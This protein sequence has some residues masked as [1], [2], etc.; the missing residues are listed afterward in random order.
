ML[1]LDEQIARLADHAEQAAIA[2]EGSAEGR[3]VVV[4]LNHRHQRRRRWVAIAA[5][6]TAAAGVVGLMVVP[7][8]VAPESPAA[9]VPPAASTAAPATNPAATVFPE[10]TAPRPTRFPALPAGDPRDGTVTGGYSGR[11]VGGFDGPVG[12]AVALV[13]RIAGDEIVDGVQIEVL[14]EQRPWITDISDSRGTVTVGGREYD[15]WEERGSPVI[16]WL[17]DRDD[18]RVKISGIDPDAYLTLLGTLPVRDIVV[19]G[20]TVGFNVTPPPGWEVV[21]APTP[22]LPSWIQP[23][24]IVPAPGGGEPFSVDVSLAPDLPGWGSVHRLRRVDVNGV[25]G[26]ITEEAAYIVFWPLGGG[27]W[28]TAVAGTSVDDALELARSVEFVDEATW[29]ERY[30]V[31]PEDMPVP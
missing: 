7:R 3:G 20:G 30:D 9:T 6:G 2:A 29:R 14:A 26:W 31:G 28:A 4:D 25:E 23:Q 12:S 1:T 16:R 8:W 27:E 17:V 5:V 19:D 10:S 13:A 22:R 15:V 21:V 18:P 24:M 11:S